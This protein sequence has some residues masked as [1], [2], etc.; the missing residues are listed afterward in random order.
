MTEEILI[1]FIINARDHLERANEHLLALENDPRALDRLDG[2]LRDLHS[3][4]GNAGF[5]NL[6]EIFEVT[7]SAEN[8]LQDLRQKKEA[9]TAETIELLFNSLD[10]LELMVSE[11]ESGG[12]ED[13]P[14]T[15]RL[16][17]R[18]NML[19]HDEPGRKQAKNPF[20]APKTLPS[21]ARQKEQGSHQA[22]K[23]NNASEITR[24]L[25]GSEKKGLKTIRL[26]QND[27]CGGAPDLLTQLIDLLEINDIKTVL[28]DLRE[29]VSMK[30]SEA[31][32]LLTLIHL[33]QD[34]AMAGVVVDP[35]T[36]GGLKRALQVLET[37]RPFNVFDDVNG[38]LTELK[39]AKASR[40]APLTSD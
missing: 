28:F 38:A 30:S 9:P 8:I 11:V 2:L 34:K 14:G 23:R 15:K 22:H 27:L 5:L 17:E 31:E 35:Q 16:M 21:S 18:L 20:S 19:D 1:E 24:P 12:P 7:H 36:Q 40:E 37:C 4:K 3:I 10:L 32:S 29:I 33:A 39:Q 13:T 25:S 26:H 6:E